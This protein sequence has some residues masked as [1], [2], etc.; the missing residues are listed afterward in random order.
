MAVRHAGSLETVATDGGFVRELAPSGGV[1][2]ASADRAALRS[3][4]KPSPQGHHDGRENHSQAERDA[5]HHR[6]INAEGCDPGGGSGG[7]WSEPHWGRSRTDAGKVKCEGEVVREGKTKVGSNP[8]SPRVS[9]WTVPS[10]CQHTASLRPQRAAGTH[11][12]A[13]SRPPHSSRCTNS[14]AAKDPTG[15]KHKNKAL[16]HQCIAVD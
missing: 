13:P 4:A 14:T 6:H 7:R 8:H 5:K 10:P 12:P 16:V 15:L 2:G 1:H 9:R 3:L 11:A